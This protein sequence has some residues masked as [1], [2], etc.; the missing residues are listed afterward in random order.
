MVMKPDQYVRWTLVWMGATIVVTVLL[1]AL[2][3]C[4]G[5]TSRFDPAPVGFTN[6][7]TTGSLR[8]R[9]ATASELLDAA[10]T[11]VIPEWFST[12]ERKAVERI[13]P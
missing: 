10:Q 3:G 5:A 1:V 13:R 2:A 6:D 11:G 4:S 8:P 9:R 7:A 12:E